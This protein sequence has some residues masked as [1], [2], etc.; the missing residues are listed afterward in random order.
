MIINSH[1]LIHQLSELGHRRV[2]EVR[3]MFDTIAQI[4]LHFTPWQTCSISAS[5]RSNTR[6]LSV[7]KNPPL[8]IASYSLLQV[9]EPGALESE[10]TCPRV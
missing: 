3:P 5:L 2:I 7:H 10:P 8:S 4:T 6:R 9:S 1:L